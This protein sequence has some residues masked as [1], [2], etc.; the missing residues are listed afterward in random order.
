MS[1]ESQVLEPQ[2]A[3]K[4]NRHQMTLKLTF[5][6]EH[7]P[8]WA[9]YHCYAYGLSFPNIT[10]VHSRRCSWPICRVPTTGIC[11]K[12][13]QRYCCVTHKLV[14]PLAPQPALV[15]FRARPWPPRAPPAA[16]VW[17]QIREKHVLG[18]QGLFL[19]HGGEAEIPVV[20]ALVKLPLMLRPACD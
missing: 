14:F 20:S 17:Q 16:E 19:S 5:L 3:P 12:Q 10:S 1:D 18:A 8:P 7:I 11:E 9:S 6:T 15:F 13:H 2:R 4:V